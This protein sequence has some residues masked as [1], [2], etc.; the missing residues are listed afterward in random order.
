MEQIL[1]TSRTFNF[2]FPAGMFPVIIARLRG[3][4]PRIK[5][6]VEGVPHEKLTQQI[7]G[8]WS[9]QENLGHLIDLEEL[10]HARIID[11]RNHTAVLRAADMKNK[12]TEEENYNN[13]QIADLLHAFSNARKTFIEELL[14][15]SDE[16]LVISSIHPRLNKEM[17]VLD[18]AYF[19]AEHDDNHITRMLA[20][21]DQFI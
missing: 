16:D 6:I 15:F 20:I 12:R 17:R 4:Y 13:K 3:A 8:K 18:M 5:D 21:K 14:K 10:H 19:V 1:W 2:D 9:M 7:N 11:F